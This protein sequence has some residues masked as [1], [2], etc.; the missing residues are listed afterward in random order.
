MNIPAGARDGTR[1][2][3]TGR[4]EP[5]ES[6][7]ANGDLY[8]IVNILPDNQFV[9]D[10][11]DIIVEVPVAFTDAALGARIRVPTLNGQAELNIPKGTQ[12]GQS[13]RLRG[14]GLPGMNG[15][16]QGDQLVRVTVQVP[17]NLSEEQER[18]IRELKKSGL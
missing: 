13:F 14:L 11:N 9:R 5:G 4:G 7:A 1:L 10:E 12:S 8:I 18:L 17:K 2:R 3:I 6:G 16:G 15:R